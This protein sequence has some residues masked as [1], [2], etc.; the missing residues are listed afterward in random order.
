VALAPSRRDATAGSALDGVLQR[1]KDRRHGRTGHSHRPA[2]RDVGDLRDGEQSPACGKRGQPPGVGRRARQSPAR[3][4]AAQPTPQVRTG[5][6][7]FP[8]EADEAL[9]YPAHAGRCHEP[10]ARRAR[11]WPHRG[12]APRCRPGV[13]RRVH[14]HGIADWRARG[15][16]DAHRIEYLML[17][18]ADEKAGRGG[19][20]GGWLAGRCRGKRG[21]FHLDDGF[22]A[23]GVVGFESP[24]GWHGRSESVR[25][26]GS[27]AYI[28]TEPFSR[29][30]APYRRENGGG[31][32][33]D[34]FFCLAGLSP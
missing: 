34:A 32:A 19:G 8:A 30:P 11:R 18:I 22:G 16:R 12:G 29:W 15:V 9:E 4:G 20:A 3:E 7:S 14:E 17:D 31:T 28:T 27:V 21:L 1:R 2:K 13:G 23:P 25:L 5:P 24:P 10:A 33:R 26:N 6:R